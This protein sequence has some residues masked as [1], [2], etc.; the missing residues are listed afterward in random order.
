MAR[1]DDEPLRPTLPDEAA[2]PRATLDDRDAPTRATLDDRD[3]PARPTLDGDDPAPADEGATAEL[4]PGEDL[5]TAEI[6]TTEIAP[7]HDVRS[8]DATA[9]RRGGRV[10]IL[11]AVLL[12]AAIVGPLVFWLGFWRFRPTAQRHIPSGTV[13]AVRVDARELYLFTPFREHVLPALVPPTDDR[14]R[15]NA[16]QRIH[17]HTGVDLSRDAREIV[18]ATTDGARWA[19]LVGGRFQTSTRRGP[20]LDGFEQAMDP[21]PG[22]PAWSR[23]G[24][25]LVGPGGAALAQADDGTLILGSTA[26]VA[27]AA[28]PATED[29]R[30]LWLSSAGD[31]S[32]SIDRAA[33]GAIV[34][35]TRGSLPEIAVLE[36]AQRV[37]GFVKLD[38]DETELTID[39]LASAGEVMEPFHVEVE[40]LVR[41]LAARV[42]PTA[43]DGAA[44]GGSARA[45]AAEVLG[46]AKVQARA[47]SVMITSAA[48]GPQLDAAARDLAAALG[49]VAS[50]GPQNAPPTA[51]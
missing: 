2:P 13:V 33:L 42:A 18:L 47:E 37:T 45:I 40:A 49:A 24:E 35:R 43:A 50:L 28:L 14:L 1:S 6:E 25:L 16:V 31:V 23:E 32:F 26:D 27:R 30:E 36:R 19:V 15:P 41:A 34:A 46:K 4:H 11:V 5:P 44:P 7:A 20:F 8:P 22:S 39:V 38:D 29:Y 10:W 3:P 12:L 51:R 9:P 48:L 17:T 21:E